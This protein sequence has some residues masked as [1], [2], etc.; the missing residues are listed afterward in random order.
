MAPQFTDEHLAEI[1][2][3][4]SQILDFAADSVLHKCISVGYIWALRDCGV[5]DYDTD[6]GIWLEEHRTKDEEG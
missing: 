1:A 3:D 6:V 5:L 4:L 2:V